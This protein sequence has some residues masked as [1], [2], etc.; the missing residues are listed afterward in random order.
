MARSLR[1]FG[2]AGLFTLLAIFSGSGQAHSSSCSGTKAGQNLLICQSP[3]LSWRDHEMARLVSMLQ[4]RMS[5]KERRVLGSEQ[6]SFRRTRDKC[7]SDE[8]CIADRYDERI[9]QLRIV[10]CLRESRCSG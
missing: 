10:E 2:I 8:D 5:R 4:R 1:R 3:R 6:R 7:G 9:H